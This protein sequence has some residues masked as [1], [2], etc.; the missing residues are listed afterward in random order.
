[1]DKQILLDIGLTKNEVETYLTLIKLGPSTAVTI[2]KESKL[3]RPNV[4]V[5]LDSLTKKSLTSYIKK[6][7]ITYHEII[8][9]EQLRSFIKLKE[10]K[11]NTIIPQ[12]KLMQESA[13]PKSE[14]TILEGIAGIRNTFLEIINN[15]KTIYALGVPKNFAKNIGE[16]WIKEWH[17][18]RIKN[19]VMF[20]HLVNEDYHTSRINKLKKMKFTTIKHLPKEYGTPTLSLVYDKGVVL[21]FENPMITIKILNKDLARTYKNYFN[22]LNKL[23][24]DT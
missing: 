13:L 8:D 14:T 11:I 4:Y 16:G 9:P 23:S 17:E 3:H 24:K 12:L 5:A 6:G 21:A 15:T 7:N 1:M 20:H 19:K 2:A 10:T 22:M 18:K